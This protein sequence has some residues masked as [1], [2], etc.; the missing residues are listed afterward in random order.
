[1]AVSNLA[2]IMSIPLIPRLVTRRGPITTAVATGIFGAFILALMPFTAVFENAA[3]LFAVRSVAVG[4]S[5]AVVQSFMMGAVNENERATVYGFAYT[6]WGVGVSL[7]VLIGGE[8]FGAGLL[9]LPFVAAVISYV[10]SSAA[11]RL[12]FSKNKPLEEM[13]RFS[14]PRVSE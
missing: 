11:L 10:F 8:L 2:T 9:T 4:V 6:A 5:W 3:A 7:G 12:F 13:T 14:M 1:M